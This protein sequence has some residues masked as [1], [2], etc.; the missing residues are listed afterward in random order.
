MEGEGFIAQSA[1]TPS[2]QKTKLCLLKILFRILP[3]YSNP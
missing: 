2:G 1:Q 3:S